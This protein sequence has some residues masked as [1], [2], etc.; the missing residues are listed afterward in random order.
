M[1]TQA[2][3][4]L[5]ARLLGLLPILSLLALCTG[6]CYVL[7]TV[8]PNHVAANDTIHTRFPTIMGILEFL[9][10]YPVPATLGLF[11]LGGLFLVAAPKD[12][13]LSITAWYLAGAFVLGLWITF[14]VLLP[15]TCCH[16][17]SPMP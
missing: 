8:V 10:A 14:I 4:T 3:K 13:P 12:K 9:M 16:V 17:E 1:T 6:F 15:Q 7:K 2:S 5:P 11:F